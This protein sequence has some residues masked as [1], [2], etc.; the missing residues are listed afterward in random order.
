MNGLLGALTSALNSGNLAS[1]ITAA[2]NLHSALGTSNATKAQI[3]MLTM[4]YEMA[5]A[6]SPMDVTTMTMV[7]QSLVQMIP[8][9]PSEDAAL[10]QELGTPAIELSPASAA[11]VI[12]RIQQSLH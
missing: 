11:D 2:G 4:Q 7:C 5:Q 9:L 8:Q 6:K 1:A 3:M 10:V 12:A